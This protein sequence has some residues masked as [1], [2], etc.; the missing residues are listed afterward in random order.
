MEQPETYQRLRDYL[1]DLEKL[2]MKEKA[3][4]HT[5]LHGARDSFLKQFP[6]LRDELAPLK[7]EIKKEYVQT[8]ERIKSGEK[9]RELALER[10][11]GYRWDTNYER[12][13]DLHTFLEVYDRNLSPE[14]T[15]REE[16]KIID[17]GSYYDHGAY[18]DTEDFRH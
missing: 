7:E 8:Q 9:R 12:L 10:R 3:H 4:S 17:R 11:L 1:K 13:P 14:D 5:D 18:L 6:G 16:N 15:E 2:I